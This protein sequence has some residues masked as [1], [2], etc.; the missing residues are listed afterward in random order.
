MRSVHKILDIDLRESLK[1]TVI[2]QMSQI[3][4][5]SAHPDW[6]AKL[7]LQLYHAPKRFCERS[8]SLPGIAGFQCHAIQDRSK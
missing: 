1:Y 4:N 2:Q 3:I 8:S 7:K 6:L 5:Q